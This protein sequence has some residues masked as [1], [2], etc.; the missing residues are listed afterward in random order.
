MSS[1]EKIPL[2]IKPV[3]RINLLTTKSRRLVRVF[4]AEETTK[5]IPHPIVLSSV[6]LPMVTVQR[7]VAGWTKHPIGYE[8][9]L[10]TIAKP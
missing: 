3:S 5:H 7:P 9:Q 8:V 2:L 10:P 1:P 6:P 4:G